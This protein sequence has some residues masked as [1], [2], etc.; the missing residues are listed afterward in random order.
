MPS[1]HDRSTQCRFNAGPP[2]PALA[3][4]HSTLDS[5]FCWR[6]CVSRLQ[7]DTDAMSVKG[8]ASVAGDGQYN[9]IE[10]QK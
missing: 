2:A 7:A 9:L 6:W 4:Y 10:S 8:W 5:A 3:I 1:K